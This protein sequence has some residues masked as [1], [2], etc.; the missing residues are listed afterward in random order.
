MYVGVAAVPSV[1][2]CCEKWVGITRLA[3]NSAL[4]EECEN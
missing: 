1:R 2:R 4:P 3:N